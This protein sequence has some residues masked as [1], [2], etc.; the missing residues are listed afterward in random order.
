MRRAV[1]YAR[2][3]AGP[4]QTDQSIEGQVAECTRYAEAH[5]LRVVDVYADHHVSGKSTEGRDEFL[6]TTQAAGF[7]MS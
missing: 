6:R 4:K 5:E 2:Y 7:S 3:S 1:I